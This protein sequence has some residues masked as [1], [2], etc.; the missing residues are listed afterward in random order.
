MIAAEDRNRNPIALPIRARAKTPPGAHRIQTTNGTLAA[1]NSS[2][3]PA[4]CKSCQHPS[5]PATRTCRYRHSRR[6]APSPVQSTNR[7]WCQKLP[8]KQVAGI[9]PRRRRSHR[10]PGRSRRFS[11]PRLGPGGL[12]A[13]FSFV[14]SRPGLLNLHKGAQTRPAP[15]RIGLQTVECP[16][17]SALPRNLITS[18]CSGVRTSTCVGFVW[19]RAWMRAVCAG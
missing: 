12:S 14:C 5:S 1:Q 9:D 16:H 4:P 6:R 7:S 13:G 17:S 8:V 15:Q 18:R 11:L 10:P 19:V 3:S 2:P